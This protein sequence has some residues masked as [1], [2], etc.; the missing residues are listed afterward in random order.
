ML[1]WTYNS[2][3][4]RGASTQRSGVPDQIGHTPTPLIRT[5]GGSDVRDTT[6]WPTGSN[7]CFGHSLKL[8]GTGLPLEPAGIGGV[9]RGRARF[10]RFM[11]VISVRC[12]TRIHPGL[13]L[14]RAIHA[15]SPQSNKYLRCQNTLPKGR[16]WLP[17][18][19]GHIAHALWVSR[20]LR[21]M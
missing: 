12:V 11:D 18:P 10:K 21:D 17:L 2:E 16:C 14:A 19:G 20:R 13:H 7:W 5:F 1:S 15:G 4:L 3:P 6:H 8:G 9:C